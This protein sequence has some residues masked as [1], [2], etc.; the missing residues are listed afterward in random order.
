M[1][2][3]IISHIYNEEYLLPWWLNHHK[4]YFDHGIIIDY[5]STDRSAEIVKEICPTWEFVR[6]K[7]SE[8]N[9][10]ELQNEVFEYESR[11]GEDVWKACLNVTEFL[12]GDFNS[13][14]STLG[15]NIIPCLYFID[16][17]E[18]RDSST[19]S[20]DKPLWEIIKTGLDVPFTLDFRGS[21]A[22]HTPNFRYPP[23]RHFRRIINT[24]RFIIFNY[25][26]APMTEEFYKRKLQVQ[27]LIPYEERVKHNGGAHTDALNP[28]GLTRE[29]LVEMYREYV[30]IDNP[31]FPRLMPRCTDLTHVM[32]QFLSRLPK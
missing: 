30:P 19:L 14:D 5:D 1:K 26:F 20:Y 25:G 6:S 10:V 17:Q 9:E 13:L 23:G 16:D 8:Y 7:N 4:K 29:R 31:H 21:R 28:N 18:L 22:I 32:N 27:E 2:K 11:Y 15:V 24:D 12:I 3:V